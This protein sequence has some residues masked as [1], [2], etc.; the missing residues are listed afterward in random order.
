MFKEVPIR[1][2]GGAIRIE[3]QFHYP[4]KVDYSLI[5]HGDQQYLPIGIGANSNRE[6]DR[7]LIPGAPAALIGKKLWCEF[8]ARDGARN[9]ARNFRALIVVSQGEEEILP[10]PVEG[11]PAGGEE[12]VIA[13]LKFV[14]GA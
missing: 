5:L 7:F 4:H 3:L 12:E 8:V 11:D 9:A 2:E 14:E 1:R 13:I 10:V 6:R